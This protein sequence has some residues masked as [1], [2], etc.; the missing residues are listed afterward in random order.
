MARLDAETLRR[1]ALVM[2]EGHLAQAWGEPRHQG[3]IGTKAPWMPS[4]VEWR[5]IQA[6]LALEWLR[7]AARS[8]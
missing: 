1:V 3:Q 5:L 2:A 7:T 8:L 6:Q 4:L